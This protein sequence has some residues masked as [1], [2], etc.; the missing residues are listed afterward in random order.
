MFALPLVAAAPDKDQPVAI[1]QH[2]T[3]ANAIRQ[4]FLQHHR[5]FASALGRDTAEVMAL[6]G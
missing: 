4:T 5:C 3:D 1:E 6:T 2:D